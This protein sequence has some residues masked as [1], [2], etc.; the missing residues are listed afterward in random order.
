MTLGRVAARVVGV[1]GVATIVLAGLG[2]FAD[3]L[4]AQTPTVT[5]LSVNSPSASNQK[6]VHFRDEFWNTEVIR[7]K[8]AFSDSVDVTGTPHVVLGIDSCT[9]C[10]AEYASGTGTDTLLFAYEVVYGDTDSTGISIAADALQLN[11]GTIT[12]SSGGAAANLNLGTHAFTDDASR[13]VQTLNNGASTGNNAGVVNI[14]QNDPASGDTYKLGETIWIT[15]VFNRSV[16][17]RGQNWSN[18]IKVLIKIGDKVRRMDYDSGNQSTNW[19]FRYAVQANDLDADGYTIEGRALIGG[20]ISHF[21]SRHMGRQAIV[22]DGDRKVDGSQGTPGITSVTLGAPAGGDTHFAGDTIQ[23]TVK[24]TQPVA[25]DT[26]G[27]T[28]QLGLQIGANT[29][30]AR[31]VSGTGT[32]DLLFRYVV[33]AADSDTDGLS[34]FGTHLGLSGG[35]ITDTVSASPTNVVRALREAALGNQIGHKVDGSAAMGVVGLALTSSPASGDTYGLSEAIEARVTFNRSVAVTGTPQLDLLLGTDTVQADYAGGTGTS[36][37]TF[38]HVVASG[39]A[40]ADGLSVD[41][42]KLNSGTINDARSGGAAAGLALGAHAISDA[43]GH[44]VDGSVE[45]APNVTGVSFSSA[46]ATGSTYG[47][48]EQIEVEVTFDKLVDVT[49]TDGTPS[50]ALGIGTATRQAD[51]ASGTGTET[52]TFGY[53]VAAMDEDTDGVSVNALALNGG[54]ITISGGTTA[55]NLG[56]GSHAISNDGDH[57]V[58]AATY[59]TGL[60]LNDPV[61]GDTYEL[62][63]TIEVVVEFNRA[64][65][66]TTTGG[67]PQLTLGITNPRTAPYVSGTGTTELTFQYEVAAVDLDNDGISIG[68]SALALNGGT[69][70]VAGG[71]ADAVLSLA[72][73]EIT[74]S[75]DHKVLGNLVAAAVS[76]VAVSSTPPAA[77]TYGRDE[78]IEVEVTFTRGVNVVTTGGTPQLALEVGA[79]TRQAVYVSGTG[80][81]VL[82]FRYVVVALDKDGDGIEVGASALT[83]NSGAINDVRRTTPL[84]ASLG[85]GTHALTAPQTGHQVDGTIAPASVT[86]L[87][88]AST[89]DAST[90]G[91]GEQIAL[92]VQ[93]DRAVVVTDAP[94]LALAIDAVARQARYVQGSGTAALT[95]E[96]W[97]QGA[98]SGGAGAGGHDEGGI[99]VTAS[100]LTLN[101]GTIKNAADGVR[102]AVLSLGTHVTANDP[103]HRVDGRV[104]A[105]PVVTRARVASAPSGASYRA[106]EEIEVRVAFSRVVAVTGVPRLALVIGNARRQAAYAS[107]SGTNVLAFRY[108]VVPADTDPDG[109]SVPE[110]ALELGAGA[111][112]VIAGGSAVADVALGSYALENVEGQGVTGGGGT[113]PYFGAA[114]YEFELVEDVP[115]PLV[116]GTVAAEDPFGGEVTYELGDGSE[117]LFELDARSGEVTY[118]GEGTDAEARSNYVMEVRAVAGDGRVGRAVVRVLVVNVN[119]PPAFVM[120]RFEFG[121][122]ENA[123]GPVVVGVAQAVDLDESDTLRYALE[124]DGG[125]GGLFELDAATGEVTYVGAGEDYEADGTK[126]WELTVSA[127]D[128]AGLRAEVVVAVLL[129]D[130]NE[131]PAFADTAYAFVLAEN[132]AGPVVLGKVA[133]VDPDAGDRAR[134]MLAEGDAERFEVVAASGVVRYVG[135]G[136]DAEAEPGRW[137]LVVRA[138]DGGGLTADVRVEVTVMD[139]NEP[140]VFGA[141]RYEWELN[142]GMA[143]PVAL[144][145]VS[146]V[147]ADV[148]DTVRY[149]LAG[150]DSERFEVDAATGEVR[151]AGEG[152]DYETGP[153]SWEF[154][155]VAVDRAGLSATTAAVVTLL[156]VNEAPVFADSAYAYE[157]SEN[158]P[159]PMALGMVEATDEDEGDVV[160]YS[161]AEGDAGRFEVD[162]ATGEVRYV[163]AGE[164]YEAGPPEYVLAVQATDAGGLADTASVTVAVLN[165]NEAPAFADTAY[166]FELSENARGPVLLGQT[167]ATDPDEGD[168]LTYSLAEGDAGRFQVDGAT[169]EVR[170]VGPGEDYEAGPASFAL[171]VR[172]EDAGGLSDEVRATVE[173][174]DENEGPEALGAMAPKVLE[175]YGAAA[176]EDLAPYFR[177][178]D[179]D[180]LS[181]V[182]ESSS[183]GVAIASVTAG[184]RLSIAPQALGM[185]MVTVTAS[186]PGGLT[187]TQQVQVTVEPSRSERARTLQMALTAFG[188]SLGAETVDVIGGR[189]GLESSSGGSHVSLGGRSLDCGSFGGEL[190]SQQCGIGSLARS[191]SSLLGMQFT[192]PRAAGAGLG[193]GAGGT[194]LDMAA[195]LFGGDGAMGGPGAMDAMDGFGAG[196]TYTG[197]QEGADGSTGA[198][199]FDPLSSRD[200]LTGSSFQLSFG[201]NASGD[202]ASSTDADASG[203]GSATAGVPDSAAP[204]AS[205]SRSGWTLWGQANGSEFESAPNDGLLLEGGTRSIYAGLDYRFGSG[206]LL[207]L[208]GS[209]SAL[210]SEFT[211]RHNGTGTV[212]ARLTS[213]YP[214]LHWSPRQGLGLWGLVGAGRG[215]A[216]LTE[217]VG[218]RFST[219]IRMRMA[220]VGARQELIGPLALRADAFAVRIESDAAVDLAGVTA[221]AQRVRFAPELSGQWAVG[222]GAALQGR[223]DLGGRWDGGDAES[224]L[225]AEAGAALG[226]AHVPT[227]FSFEARGRALVA[228]QTS[229]FREWGA[230]FAVR[231]Q[232]GRDQ[233]GL[234]FSVEPTW[235]EAASGA[236]SLW[237][238]QAGFA[239]HQAAPLGDP[240]AP[241]AGTALGGNMPGWTPDRVALEL[242]WGVVLPGG[243]QVTPFGRWTRHGAD[244]YRLNAGTRWELLGTEPTEA[245]TPGNGNHLDQHQGLRFAIDL[246]GEQVA[247]D[248][249]PTEHRIG[250][251]G[252]IGFK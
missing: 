213:T 242:G 100:G 163:G 23:A 102:N 217:T 237:Q 126:S 117:G 222:E 48:N 6:E 180:A 31:Y 4:A 204:Q 227:G 245:G 182:A 215:S 15:L 170:Y 8:V 184:G 248:V 193:G 132:A 181:Y 54:T 121:L 192:A 191:A 243:A 251:L 212:D 57:L 195:L 49:T 12:A 79:N 129:R 56:L 246:F 207:G 216:D 13:Q 116:V 155:V 144:G 171:T 122:P 160:E 196:G 226:F 228:H 35:T 230:G 63:D 53:D 174:L 50:L 70:K 169:G 206:L 238:A 14:L 78:A 88:F 9:D 250:I 69:I 205:P 97:V 187:A 111:A 46:P 77:S 229:A 185:A 247:S 22:N 42:L 141:E 127:T 175:A 34:T 101:G 99:V 74:N 38:R 11:S 95:F 125:A 75:A 109:F 198:I 214:Y 92:R 37:L 123:V 3:Q 89:P 152:E 244:G 110:D 183:P 146:A 158:A 203:T 153:T 119:D 91:L 85:L 115:G 176:E 130:E 223:L 98:G 199:E 80:T 96:Y 234:S 139:E 30:Q 87:S 151:Y 235:G 17:F 94:Q 220:A 224:G 233:G 178:P 179:G 43:G 249:Q 138:T 40:D 147:D 66:V 27:G 209:R 161:L 61:V 189:L 68:A 106:G 241:S 156:D 105:V 210:D 201:G 252:K 26:T 76:G 103:N 90:Y 41:T 164:D 150:P 239:P 108:R 240:T 113:D 186:D 16:G 165:E 142:E 67:T 219:D 10:F 225:G 1:V 73:H 188:R 149:L 148:A 24:F 71:T 114:E 28:P 104:E 173:L 159:G 55:A 137:E 107:G 236:Q 20:V 166:A 154:T 124:S 60:T 133:A 177:D 172:V 32:T 194:H 65:D 25:V 62:R 140:P 64:V 72:G 7:V 44:K 83:L 145:M 131:A 167:E 197:Q 112:I 82:T 134:Y 218:G 52:L 29:R 157:L 162:G 58:D 84:A 51:Y 200:L 118:V 221:V 143:G 45:V 190:G 135:A 211:S 128:L 120:E 33:V 202:P 208:A 36:A 93:F 5:G 231:L 168:A 59:V 18:Q 21:T 81:K 232:P 2:G 19:A 39:D 47:F 136:E 86:G